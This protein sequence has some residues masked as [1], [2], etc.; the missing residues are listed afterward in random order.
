M[1]EKASAYLGLI[2]YFVK[3]PCHLTLLIARRIFSTEERRNA[4]VL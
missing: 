4:L 1:S 3:D 2:G